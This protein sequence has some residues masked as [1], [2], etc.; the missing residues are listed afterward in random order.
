MHT[1]PLHAAT[2]LCACRACNSQHVITWAGEPMWSTAGLSFVC[3]RVRP[4]VIVC[5]SRPDTEREPMTTHRMCSGPGSSASRHGA[6]GTLWQAM[7]LVGAPARRPRARG[8]AA[9]PGFTKTFRVHL[10]CTRK[11][12]AHEHG[13]ARLAPL[14]VGRWRGSRK[15]PVFYHFM[16]VVGALCCCHTALVSALR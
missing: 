15:P 6:H 14:T 11:G 9:K 5:A 3:A 13:S 4:V 8:A 7:F 12:G 2:V 16:C 1:E 10:N